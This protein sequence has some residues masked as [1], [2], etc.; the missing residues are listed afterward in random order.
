MTDP[1]SLIPSYRF[2]FQGGISGTSHVQRVFHDEGAKVPERFSFSLD[3]LPLIAGLGQRLSH[4]LADLIDVAVSIFISDR[5]APRTRTNDQR[6]LDVRWHRKLHLVVPVRDP[7]HWRQP[8]IAECLDE[9]L[10]FLTNDDW[11][12]DFTN[13]QHDP[14][15]S[16]IQASLFEPPPGP[17]TS[18]LHSGGLDSLFGMIDRLLDNE[19]ATVMPVTVTTNSKGLALAQDVVRELRGA[20]P[21]FVSRLQ[22]AQLQI[23]LTGGIRSRDDRESSH[24][25]R[26]VLFLAAGIITAA[27]TDQSHLFVCENG[28]GAIGLPMTP[29][30]WG[31]RATKAMHP[32]TLALFA[33]LSSLAL[34]RQISIH[35]LGLFATKAE[36]VERFI[37]GPFAGVARATVSCDRATY[38]SKGKACGKCTSCL[39]R[40]L[41]LVATGTDSLIDEGATDYEIDWLKPG[42]DWAPENAI[43][44][45]AMRTQVER[46]RL[47]LEGNAGFAGIASEFPD[48]CKV[49]DIAPFLGCSAIEIENN[50]LRLYKSHVG[51]FDALVAKIDRPGWGRASSLIG[52]PPTA[53]SVMAS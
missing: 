34:N 10:Y 16:E 48:L 24:R 26:V 49:L 22:P 36:L 27:L 37:D 5:L 39:F 44:L 50:L 18:V 23:N 17:V 15:Q 7:Q 8:E 1:S 28:V 25:T 43:P 13:R 42:A 45:V 40:R 35:N 11:T 19:V 38:S 9:L 33:Q 31:P 52:L 14:R 41:A 21:W 46:M 6:P 3:D 12:I 4:C 32:R 47:A 30:Q 53:A 29:D 51:E 2:E 20:D